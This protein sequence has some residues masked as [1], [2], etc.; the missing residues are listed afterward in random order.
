MEKEKR[1]HR[2]RTIILGGIRMLKRLKQ[3][4]C[5]HK[6]KKQIEK[7]KHLN[8]QTYLLSGKRCE[9]CGKEKWL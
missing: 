5:R 9:R 4:L 2:T 8:G 1:N 6:N 7:Y 3:L